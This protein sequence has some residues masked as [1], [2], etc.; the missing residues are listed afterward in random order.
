MKVKPST[1]KIVA[2][3]TNPNLKKMEMMNGKNGGLVQS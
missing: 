3:D 2:V 1:I